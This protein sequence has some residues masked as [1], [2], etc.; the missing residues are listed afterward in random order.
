MGCWGCI[1]TLFFVLFIYVLLTEGLGLAGF[2]SF[3]LAMIAVILL[4]FVR[5]KF[6]YYRTAHKISTR[7]TYNSFEVPETLLPVE[8][9]SCKHHICYAAVGTQVQCQNCGDQVKPEP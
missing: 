8:C 5:Y 3:L 4:S 2:P 6:V 9:P 1:T 7:R